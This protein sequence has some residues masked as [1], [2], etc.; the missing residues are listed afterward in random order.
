ME[1][2]LCQNESM[3]IAEY[4]FSLQA[5]DHDP[6]FI[7]QIAEDI[8]KTRILKIVAHILYYIQSK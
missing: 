4:I 2:S 8:Q 6:F 7:G 3:Q 5:Q 1:F